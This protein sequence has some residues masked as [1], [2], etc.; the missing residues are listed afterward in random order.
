V[1]I[2]GIICEYN[3]F[4]NGHAG[5]IKKTRRLIN[6]ETAIVCIMSG[7]YVQ[8]GDIAVFNKHKRA[9]TAVMNGADLILE[10]PTPYVL[11]S[12]EGFA[13]AGIR[14]LDALNICDHISFGSEANDIN[15]LKD[16]AEIIMSNK[17]G[18][19]T[20]E[21][22]DEG[23]SYASAQQHAANILM[24][25][26]ADVFKSPNNVLGIE[27]LKALKRIDSKMKPVTVSRTG[28]EH[29]SDTGC[30]ASAIR[31]ILL[32]GDIPEALLP[33]SVIEICKREILSGRGP[34][35]IE[36]AEQALLSRLRAVSDFSEILGISEGLD[37][38]FK[39][40]VSAEPTIESI[41]MKIKTK[42]YPMSR[43][44]RILICAALNITKEYKIITPPYIKVLA[45]NDTGM[46]ILKQAR[47]KAKLP[48]ITKPAAVSK[49]C[50]TS[51]KLFN[52]ESSATDLYTLA[53][54]NKNER[55]GSSEWRTSPV[56]INIRV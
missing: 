34:V 13:D 37:Q 29:D 23:V 11:M 26:N 28:G 47:K 49:L 25:K 20:K 32:S 6:D 15:L 24:G 12:A 36:N 41:L 7:N 54:Q 27:Y 38:R 4:H 5:H 21:Q 3:P 45:M 56:I 44:R 1:K 19:I 50:E 51:K 39:K 8:R 55:T 18:A 30:S 40:N 35:S 2:T 9:E 33:D 46:N 10:L 48:I 52:L 16:T 53:Y 31:K 22:L 43:L 17:A 42:R 14:I